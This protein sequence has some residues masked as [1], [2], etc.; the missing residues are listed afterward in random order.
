MVLKMP[1]WAKIDDSWDADLYFLIAFQI[2][3]L[4]WFHVET[5]NSELNLPIGQFT[6]PSAVASFM[7]PFDNF[8]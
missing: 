2:K 7:G 5:P 6:A 3:N 1:L 8:S 4:K